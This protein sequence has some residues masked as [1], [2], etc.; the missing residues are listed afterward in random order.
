MRRAR[1]M[2]PPT[3]T[4]AAAAILLVVSAVFSLALGIGLLLHTGNERTAGDGGLGC[5]ARG[6]RVHRLDSAAASQRDAEGGRARQHLDRIPGWPAGLIPRPVRM[7]D[8][9]P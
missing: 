1:R 4:A 3:P 2:V 6:R 5:R 8:K 9:S 7:S